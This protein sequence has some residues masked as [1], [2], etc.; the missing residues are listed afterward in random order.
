[1]TGAGLNLT[2]FNIRERDAVID[3]IKQV[4]ASPFSDRSYRWRQKYLNNPENVYP[5]IVVIPGV[6]NDCSGVM[7]T[8][9]VSSGRTDEITVA[10]SRG[11]GG[12][13]EGQLAE[14]WAIQKNGGHELIAPSRELYYNSLNPQGGTKVI[15]ASLDEPIMGQARISKINAFSK[16]LINTMER[17]G[18]EGPYDVELGFKDEKIW[19]FQVR[20]FVENKGALSSE[21]LQSITPEV[22][23]KKSI[24]LNSTL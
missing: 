20:P 24:R 9:G 1:F 13:V 14:T 2:L 6:D 3:G 19:L 5:S 18:I 21:Y 10:M 16:E 12:A 4:W 22:N 8:K 17:R 7:I 23:Q 11:V 15:G